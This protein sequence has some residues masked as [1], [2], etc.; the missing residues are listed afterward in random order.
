M[1][2]WFDVSRRRIPN[3]LNLGIAVVGLVMAATAQGRVDISTA[4]SAMGISFAIMFVP[5][6]ARI[7]RGGDLKLVVG[8]SA[9]V[10]PVEAA[11]SIVTGIVLGGFIAG[12]LVL[13]D[14]RERR[15]IG[16]NLWVA[17]F[18][19]RLKAP[20]DIEQDR[21]TVPMGVAFAITFS[22]ASLGGFEWL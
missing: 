1:A 22:V 11:A 8:A 9:W 10:A 7:L 21:V 16:A 12:G 6:W 14:E 5:F 15:E 19:R 3:L 4:L 18:G 2:A 17:I 20:E 13:S